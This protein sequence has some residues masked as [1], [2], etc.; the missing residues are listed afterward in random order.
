MRLLHTERTFLNMAG[1]YSSQTVRLVAHMDGAVD[2][3]L[4]K[5]AVEATRQRYPYLCVRL[6]IVHDEQGAERYAY[7]DNP[8][9]WVLTQGEQ[10]VA[11]LGE[12]SNNHLIAFCWWDDCIALDFFYSLADG[13]SA[14]RV[15][16]TLLY[17]YCRRRYDSSLSAEGIMVAGETIDEGEYTDPATLPRPEKFIPQPKMENSQTLNLY[18]DALAP[19]RKDGKEA[20]HICVS[21]ER[22]M[23]QIRSCG[24]SPGS[25]LAVVLARVFSLLQP[26]GPTPTV[27]LAVNLRNGTGTPLAHQPMVGA[28]FLPLRKEMLDW[29][30]SEQV[31]E[32][33]RMIASKASPDHLQEYYWNLQDQIDQLE[34]VPSSEMRHEL[35]TKAHS[36]MRQAAS[37]TVSYVGRAALGA[38]DRYVRE[39]RTEGNSPLALLVEVNAAGGRFC[40]SFLQQFATDIYLDAFLNELSQM[41]IGYEIVARHPLAIAPI[42]DFHKF[43]Q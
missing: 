41:G 38:A 30:L 20:V 31:A 22:L 1:K 27:S 37:F 2:E 3:E 8:Q 21:E 16:R 39:I 32:F 11:L 23:Q 35:L 42:S 40:I 28:I 34:Q 24:A 36:M 12:A 33:R 26:D 14:Y 43:I 25:W 13:T 15:L 5:E 6:C 7:E 4:L 19:M 29:S 18:A 17:E 10:Q 9:P